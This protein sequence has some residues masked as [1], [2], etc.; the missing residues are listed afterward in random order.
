MKFKKFTTFLFSFAI[1]III[2]IFISTA[3]K[4]LLDPNRKYQRPG[5]VPDDNLFSDK[6]LN[7]FDIAGFAPPEKYTEI[8]NPNT[9]IT[10]SA[11]NPFGVKREITIGR[12]F[13][14]ILDSEEEFHDYAKYVLNFLR[15]D[16]RVCAGIASILITYEPYGP[17]FFHRSERMLL[18]GYNVRESTDVSHYFSE[19]YYENA[20]DY[21]KV[22]SLD[23]NRCYYKFYC[24]K[25]ENIDYS[26]VPMPRLG[27]VV[28]LTLYYIKTTKRLNIEVCD[29]SLFSPM[30][31]AQR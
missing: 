26:V 15:Q 22:H 17:G 4:I 31:L 25:R 7:Y 20:T 18:H 8:E 3:G 29:Y 27:Q 28:E 9:K 5:S 12:C 13:S 23:A 10:T 16:D 24:T 6:V 11:K 19:Y 1:I 14:V 2:I 30:Y 21:N